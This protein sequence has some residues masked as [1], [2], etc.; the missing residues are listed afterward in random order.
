[1]ELKTTSIIIKSDKTSPCEFII[2]ENLGDIIKKSI[3][4]YYQ[5]IASNVKLFNLTDTD[6]EIIDLKNEIE[7]LKK[8]VEIKENEI[9][10]LEI[11]LMKKKN[12]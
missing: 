8:K 4:D 9:K 3:S 10:I 5:F 2:P 11:K 6:K 12:D 7:K 1:M